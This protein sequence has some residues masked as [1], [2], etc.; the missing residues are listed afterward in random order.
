MKQTFHCSRKRYKSLAGTV[1]TAYGKR[2]GLL[3]DDMYQLYPLFK[4]V[5]GL[6]WPPPYTMEGLVPR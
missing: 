3:K 4:D 2:S 5:R 6:L 1:T